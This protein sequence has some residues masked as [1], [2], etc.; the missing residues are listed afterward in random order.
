MS[1][2]NRVFIFLSIVSLASACKSRYAISESKP[3]LYSIDQGIAPD[4][5][6]MAFYQPYKAR[7]DSQ[8][9]RVVA[10][11]IVELTR[12]KPE[13]KLNNLVADGVSAIARQNNIEFD[14]V[15]F[16]Y[17]SLRIPLPKGEVKMYKIFELMPF[18]NMLTTV[19]L[20]GK[21]INDLFQYMAGQGG[22]PVSGAT[23]K[24]QNGQ[25]RNIK[26]GSAPLDSAIKYTILTTDYF[27]N[28]GDSATVYLKAKQRKDYD[29]KQRDAFIMYLKQLSL[30]GVRLNPQLDGRV[31]SDNLQKSK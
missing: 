4:S 17:K 10:E 23:F 5:A 26:I 16:N 6:T 18:E 7:I 21:E 25:A 27:A 12:G 1:I 29:L 2:R 8:M 13:G 19:V 22:D 30:K 14:F 15:H 31:S 3:S 9:N 20:S 28:G 24:I 11:S